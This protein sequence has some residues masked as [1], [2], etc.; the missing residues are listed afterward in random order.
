[1]KLILDLFQNFM[2]GLYIY[3][4]SEFVQDFHKAAHVRS[5]EAVRQIDVDV[6]GRI[7]MLRAIRAIQDHDGVF[8]SLNAYFLYVYI[9]VIFLILNVDHG[10]FRNK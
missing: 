8:N 10:R 5:L 4:P 2:K 1:M 9:P 7:D 6:D 3:L